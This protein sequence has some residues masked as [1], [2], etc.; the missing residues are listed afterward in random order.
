[1]FSSCSELKPVLL[2][3]LL[4]FAVLSTIPISRAQNQPPEHVIT[5]EVDAPQSVYAADLDGDGSPDVLS[6]SG[7]DDKIAWY[8]NQLDESEGFSNQ[9]IITESAEFAQSVYAADL[10][11]DSDYDV[12][13]GG[14]DGTVAWHENNGSGTFGSQKVIDDEGD[15]ESV[16]TDDMDDD[17]DQDILAVMGGVGEIRLYTNDGNG[18]FSTQ[19]IYDGTSDRIEDVTSGDL[20]EDSD[21][22]VV[23]AHFLVSWHENLGNGEFGPRQDVSSDPSATSVHAA[24]LDDDGDQD[25]VAGRF[26]NVDPNEVLWFENDG[27]GNFAAA[28]VITEQVQGFA[29]VFATDLDEDGD[30]D[31]VSG[32][33][34]SSSGGKVA[35]YENLGSE[36]FGEQRIVDTTDIGG[37]ESIYLSDLDGDGDQDILSAS[38]REETSSKEDKVSWYENTE[39]TLPIDLVQFNASV[40][41]KDVILEWKT[42]NETKNSGFE[43]QRRRSGGDEAWQKV[44]F[45]ESKAAGGTTTEALR[46]RFTDKDLPYT[47]DELSYRLRQVDLGGTES[48]TE[49]VTVE[50][51]T[52]ELELRGVFPNP[53]REQASV[54]FAVPKRK[55]VTLRVYDVLGREVR[56]IASE[57]A[58]GR[59]ERQVDLSG[60]ASGT[61]FLRLSAGGQTKTRKLRVVR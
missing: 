46:Y 27:N 15:A 17:G 29:E 47:A 25:L 48:Y 35:W 8:R 22:D 33:E 38:V 54:R 32:S 10:D 59:Q 14:E 40:K 49:V 13:R 28:T 6:A 18:N 53:A 34:K 39:S 30:Q 11:G 16:Y 61:Y 7:G 52:Q 37:V 60:L 45:V 57:P 20:D 43:I 31:I 56:T 21:P 5:T 55:E 41:N 51:R 2:S 9:N 23:A 19:I 12:L 26:D 44:G 1:M 58:G 3:T 24:D 42:A 36:G 4:G 50:R